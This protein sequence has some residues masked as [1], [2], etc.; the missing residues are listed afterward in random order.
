VKPFW[1]QNFLGTHEFLD[2]NYFFLQKFCFDTNFWTQNSYRPKIFWT[3][4]LLGQKNSGPEIFSH[5][6]FLPNFFQTE[7]LGSWPCVVFKINIHFRTKRSIS[8][9]LVPKTQKPLNETL[10]DTFQ[11]VK[12]NMLVSRALHSWDLKHLYDHC[13]PAHLISRWDG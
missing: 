11:I 13:F 1:T 2:P 4:N 7:H 8:L 12:I 9:F 10:G 6:F 5:N 3:K